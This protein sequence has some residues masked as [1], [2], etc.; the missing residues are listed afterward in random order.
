[1][2]MWNVRVYVP[3]NCAQRTPGG[4]VASKCSVMV[5]AV[6]TT[7]FTF[8]RHAFGQTPVMMASTD[9][10]PV[11]FGG[12]NRIVSAETNDASSTS[13]EQRMGILRRGVMSRCEDN[14]A[15]NAGEL[16]DAR[17][18]AAR[19]SLPAACRCW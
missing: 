7:L 9:R 13:N 12:S 15:G 6:M 2:P 11:G 16:R 19:R 17:S 10:L 18:N 3:I 14:I 4:V 8:G 1:M 5:V